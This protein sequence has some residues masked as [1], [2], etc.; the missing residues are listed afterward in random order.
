MRGSP[1]GAKARGSS[2]TASPMPPACPWRTAR[3]PRTAVSAPKS[4]RSWMPSACGPVGVGAPGN[5]RTSSS[6]IRVTMRRTSVNNS[7]AA[8]SARRSRN[9]SGRASPPVAD[10]SS[11]TSHAFKPS[12]PSPGF[13]KSIAAW[14]SVGSVS[15]C[16]SMRFWRLPRSISGAKG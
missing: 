1:V 5:G 3:R 2:S 4:C 12:A 9:G 11:G 8:V 14:S 13:R 15:P 10:R 7:A 6:P 16:V